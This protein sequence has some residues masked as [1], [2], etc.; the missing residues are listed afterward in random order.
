MKVLLPYSKRLEDAGGEFLEI[1]GGV[2]F[3]HD[4]NGRSSG[5]HFFQLRYNKNKGHG[6]INKACFKSLHLLRNQV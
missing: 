2:R 4:Y 3:C 6:Q 5:K 1:T